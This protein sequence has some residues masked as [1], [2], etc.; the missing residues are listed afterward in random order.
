MTL[1]KQQA[2]EYMEITVEELNRMQPHTPI[3]NFIVY[4]DDVQRKQVKSST[5]AAGYSFTTSSPA[6]AQTNADEL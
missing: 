5:D 4:V 3:A 1:P 2:D 6:Q